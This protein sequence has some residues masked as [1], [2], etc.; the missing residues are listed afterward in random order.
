MTRPPHRRPC[1]PSR[2]LAVGHAERARAGLMVTASS[3]ACALHAVRHR[4]ARVVAGFADAVR[5]VGG[6]EHHRHAGVRQ[7]AR[8]LHG[9][10]QVLEIHRQVLQRIDDHRHVRRLRSRPPRASLRRLRRGRSSRCS[11]CANFSAWRMPSTRGRRRS[12]A[13][14]CPF[15]TRNQRLEVGARN[16]QVA[17][18]ALVVAG[19]VLLVPAHVFEDVLPAR[20][21]RVPRA[22]P[23]TWAPTPPKRL[24]HGHARLHPACRDRQRDSPPPPGLRT[25]RPR[26]CPWPGTACGVFGSRRSRPGR[27]RRR[28]PDGIGITIASVMPPS[29]A[30]GPSVVS[31][32]RP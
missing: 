29:R 12:P 2:A 11:S 8:V 31:G 21:A 20:R 19:A 4:I 26:R 7:A 13:G 16:V 30:T 15:T 17:R 3:A 22:P 6:L 32:S 9:C 23:A 1:R 27:R 25:G 10:A 18:L 5:A 28:R 24:H 14:C